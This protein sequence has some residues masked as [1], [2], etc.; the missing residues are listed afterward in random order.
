MIFSNNEKNWTGMFLFQTAGL[1]YKTFSTVI[2]AETEKASV[3]VPGTLT[4]SEDLLQLT[5]LY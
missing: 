1:F 3:F 4:E 2:N 5:S